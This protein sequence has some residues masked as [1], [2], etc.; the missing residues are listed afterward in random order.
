M[1]CATVLK[2]ALCNDASYYFHKMSHF[3]KVELISA[4]TV[5]F[6][7]FHCRALRERVLAQA[8]AEPSEIDD[9]T[10]KGMNNY[11]DH[12]KGFR[13]EH[14]IGAEKGSGIHGPL[15]APSNIRMT[16]R[17]DYQPD[18]CKVS[19]CPCTFGISGLYCMSWK[20]AFRRGMVFLPFLS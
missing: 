8:G 1:H 6:K 11:T 18:I 4:G 17:F 7:L 10:Y 16:V 5:C 9:G 14:T 20:N 2:Y 19:P 3:K 13:R 15:R 12:R